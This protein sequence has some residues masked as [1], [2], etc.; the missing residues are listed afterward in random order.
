[1]KKIAVLGRNGFIGKELYKRFEHCY[2]YLRP[3][4]DYVFWFSA[5]SSQILFKHAPEYCKK[6]TLNGFVNVLD[7][8]KENNI[9][10]IYP[11]TASYDNDYADTK[12]Q[13]EWIQSESPYKNILGYKISAGY[14][15]GEA[16]KGEYASIVYQFCKEMKEGKRPIVYGDGTQTRDFIYIDDI[17]DN[18]VENMDKTGIIDLGTGIN[19][20]FNE[21]VDIINDELKT[22]I[23]PIYIEKPK[24][25]LKDTICENPIPCKSS[26]REGI[27][28]ILN[29]A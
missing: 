14:G 26:L 25:Y 3:D 21:V 15:P 2:N 13:L 10:L 17:V 23:K 16:H 9:K 28:E 20:S 11:S 6:E 12:R 22:N 24:H 27:K 7:Y 29:E 4:L 1:M 8:C 5:A 19:H 18:I